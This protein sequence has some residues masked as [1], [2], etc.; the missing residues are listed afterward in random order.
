MDDCIFCKI[1][2]GELPSSRLYEDE[3]TLV[4]LDIHPTNPGHTLVVPKAHHENFMETPDAWHAAA[5][6]VMKKIGKALKNA[7]GAEG[8]NINMNNGK[9]AGQAVFHTH[10]HIIPRYGSDGLHLWSG[11][12]YGKGEEAEMARK[13]RAVLMQ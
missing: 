2:A 12:P 13:I 7:L 10:I 4:F 6:P 9:A 11:K 5:V 3:A 8:F 1:I